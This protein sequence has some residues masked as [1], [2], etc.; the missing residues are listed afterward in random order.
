L[1]Y[2][3]FTVSCLLCCLLCSSHYVDTVV[4]ITMGPE[5]MW[6]WWLCWQVHI[7]F[8]W[9]QPMQ[10]LQAH[11]INHVY[12]DGN[13]FFKYQFLVDQNVGWQYFTLY[14][15]ISTWIIIYNKFTSYMYAFP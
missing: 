13:P 7:G 8:F 3:S 14:I 15:S 5:M 2:R 11:F 4:L 9:C 12:N 1:L 10:S 6:W